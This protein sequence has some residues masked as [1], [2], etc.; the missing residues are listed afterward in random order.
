LIEPERLL[1]GLDA[2]TSWDELID[3]E[4]ALRPVMSQEQLDRALQAIADLADLWSPYTT[5][6]S[7]GVA[8]LVSAAARRCGLSA[9]QASELRRAALLH[10][11]GRLGVSSAIWDK[12]GPLSEA[13]FERVRIFPYFTQR[14]F[15][16]SGRLA[17]IAEIAGRLVIY[18]K[19]VG[20]H[21]EHIY[22]K[23]GCPSR[24]EASLFA[25]QRGLL[26]ELPAAR[27]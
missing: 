13:E 26:G 6:H 14:M 10:D 24:A 7:R 18:P 11:L 8:E 5:G 20:N 27:R 9:E 12:P 23:I 1:S 16:R 15:S 21:I 4:P 3:A 2:A 25:M 22:L 19:R 17:P